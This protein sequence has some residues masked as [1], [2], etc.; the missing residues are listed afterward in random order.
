MRLIIFAI[1][2]IIPYFS[3]ASE[4]ICLKYSNTIWQGEKK[5]K[6]FSHDFQGPITI[7]F[8]GQCSKIPFSKNYKINYK[9]I[10]K[11]GKINQSGTLKFK[12][13]GGIEFKHSSGCKG[14]VSVMTSE[15]LLWHDIFT[16]N[17][18]VIDVKNK[19]K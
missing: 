10:A 13:D 14:N 16:A 15:N 7:Q 2:L 1:V 12:E 3:F 11:N 5:G 6:A 17:S 4:E 9:W 8:K 19:A 18:Y